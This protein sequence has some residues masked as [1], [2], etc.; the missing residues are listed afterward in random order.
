MGARATYVEAVVAMLGAERY[1]PDAQAVADAVLESQRFG[2]LGHHKWI[3]DD[4]EAQHLLDRGEPWSHGVPE[5]E[6]LRAANVIITMTSTCR[7]CGAVTCSPSIGRPRLY[8]TSKC[9][10]DAYHERSRAS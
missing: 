7:Q 3:M 8:C 9:R 2:V 1:R 4:A 10:H 5:G 6:G